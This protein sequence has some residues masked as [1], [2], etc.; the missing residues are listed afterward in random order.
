MSYPRDPNLTFS[1]CSSRFVGNSATEPYNAVL[2]THGLL[3]HTDVSFCMD[4]ESLYKIC[5]REMGLICPSYRNI[6]RL[7]AQLASSVTGSLRF[8][9]ALNVDLLEL[10]TNLVPYPR[11]HF[12][13]PALAPLIHSDK[14]YFDHQ[15]VADITNAVFDHSSTFLSCDPRRGSYMA[16]CLMY[17]GDV[18]PKDVNSAVATIKTKRTIQ[19]VDWSPTGMKCGIVSKPPCCVPGGDLACAARGVALA[20]NTTAIAEAFSRTNHKFDL[21]FA[22]RAFLHWYVGEGMEV[23]EF[24]EAREDLASLE[25]DYK[26]CGAESDAYLWEVSGAEDLY[27]GF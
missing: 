14:A 26:E 24:S 23:G 1:I 5:L 3:E 16:C 25:R 4:N 27:S 6:N 20:A 19:F 22:K 9:G 2:S 10:Q 15:S 7:I 18:T 17:R 21:M 13:V 12:L 8:D 11:L